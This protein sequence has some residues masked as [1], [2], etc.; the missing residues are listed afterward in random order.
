MKKRTRFE[1]EF[2]RTQEKDEHE[3]EEEEKVKKKK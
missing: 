3:F 2:K 1:K